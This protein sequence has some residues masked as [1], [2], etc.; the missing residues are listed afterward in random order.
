MAKL[1]DKMKKYKF[2]WLECRFAEGP[3]QYGS[4][5]SLA[6]VESIFNTLCTS[7]APKNP[8]KRKP[9]HNSRKWTKMDSSEHLQYL[10][11][12]LLS[13]HYLKAFKSIPRIQKVFARETEAKLSV[14]WRLFHA[15]WY[16]LAK[17]IYYI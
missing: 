15:Y 9:T 10:V 11:I 2:L 13:Q 6:S 1:R 12:F 17:G 7:G 4:R 8:E 16:C 3:F 14:Y 5:A